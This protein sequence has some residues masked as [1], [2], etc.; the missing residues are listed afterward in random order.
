VKASVDGATVHQ[1]IEAVRAN[2]AGRVRA[3]LK[4]RPELIKA[5]V[6]W[7]NEH[8]AL[9]FAVMDRRPEM[10]RMLM[11]HGADARAGISPHTEATGALTI[12]RERAYDEIVAI[13]LESE[14]RREPDR[15]EPG[16]PAEKD[17]PAE[18]V[19]AILAGDEEFLRARH[20]EGALAAPLDDSGGLVGVAVEHDRPEILK[21]LLDWGLDP[22]ARVAVDSVDER[23][24]TWGMPLYHCARHGKHEM[25]Q[26]LLER[27]ADPNAQVYASGTP[28]SEAYGQRDEKMIALLERFGGKPNATMAGFY[29]RMELAQRL[30]A[31][32][33]DSKLPDDG[34][35]SGTVAE[36]LA[37]G[38]ARGGDPE[39]LRL[40]MDRINLAHGDPRWNGLLMGP[41]EMWN[42]G[43]WPWAHHEWDRGDY[44][45][46]F[47]M[48]LERCGP[49][50][51]RLRWGATVLH[52]VAASHEHVR[53]EERVAFATMLLDAGA[54][55]NIRDDLLK[56]TPLGWACRWGRVELV[57]LMLERGV[58]AVE[59]DAEAWATPLAWAR[60]RGNDELIS[61]L[62]PRGG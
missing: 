10:V 39:I 55:T 33:G 5:V 23:A 28:L 38:A 31:E 52:E 46:C 40:A 17:V 45:R 37:A 15:P 12:A 21:L 44:V 24:F 49:P 36:Q 57:K 60:K 7:N 19:R 20:V 41:L 29:R 16:P 53:R 3:V 1:L 58:D 14:G 51:A 54:R 11:E 43:P 34:F 2:D 47:K 32:H 61:L 30:L 25:A 26:M 27:G 50:N 9:H 56:S 48:I 42:H 4:A 13:I 22:D 35:G 18:F 62:G 6:A 59:A 8:S